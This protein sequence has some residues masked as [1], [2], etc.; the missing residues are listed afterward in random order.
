MKSPMISVGTGVPSVPFT[1]MAQPVGRRTD[2]LQDQDNLH[3]MGLHVN[4]CLV[5]CCSEVVNNQEFSFWSLPVMGT[6]NCHP[7]PSESLESRCAKLTPKRLFLSSAPSVFYPLSRNFSYLE[8]PFRKRSQPR[9]GWFGA[10]HH[11]T[12]W[13]MLPKRRHAARG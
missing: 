3:D 4:S 5:L 12:Q 8:S 10:K 6:R 7:K 13:L 1:T 2:R 9:R 11:C